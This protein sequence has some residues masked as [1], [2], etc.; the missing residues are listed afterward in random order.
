MNQEQMNKDIVFSNINLTKELKNR[1]KNNKKKN[2]KSLT[3]KSK[4]RIIF[5]SLFVI[6]CSSGLIINT[7]Q[8]IGDFHEWQDCSKY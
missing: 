3:R 8:L 6:L 2:P 7:T 1:T 4:F 5:K